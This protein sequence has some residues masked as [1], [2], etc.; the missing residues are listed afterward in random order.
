MEKK[1]R[2]FKY[3][4]AGRP[5]LNKERGYLAVDGTFSLPIG[6]LAK[7]D[8]LCSPSNSRSCLVRAALDSYLDSGVIPEH[9]RI[10]RDAAEY[11]SMKVYKDTYD[12]LWHAAKSNKRSGADY[13]RAAIEVVLNQAKTP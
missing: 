13:V 8:L 2:Q 11:V 6:F 5:F 10:P 9:R 1:N 7:L 4:T 3:P 12:R